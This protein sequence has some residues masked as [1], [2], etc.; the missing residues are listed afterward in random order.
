MWV[1]RPLEGSIGFSNGQ[2]IS[3]VPDRSKKDRWWDIIPESNINPLAYTPQ[4]P[5]YSF[6]FE[7]I[8]RSQPAS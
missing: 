2:T 5:D 1:E 8:A 6:S 3:C 4:R 7:T